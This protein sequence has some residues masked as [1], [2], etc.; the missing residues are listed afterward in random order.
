MLY[1]WNLNLLTQIWNGHFD[2]EMFINEIHQDLHGPD[3][4]SLLKHFLRSICLHSL[5]TVF[6]TKSANLLYLAPSGYTIFSLSLLSY[7]MYTYWVIAEQKRSRDDCNCFFYS[8][9]FCRSF[10]SLFIFSFA[11]IKCGISIFYLYR[12][13]QDNYLSGVIPSE[14]GNLSQLENL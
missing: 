9:P 2:F 12:F 6:K 1:F 7:L 3:D 5:L 11:W 4:L 13:L 14:L 8:L 10:L